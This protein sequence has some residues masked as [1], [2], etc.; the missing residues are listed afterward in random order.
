MGILQWR[1]VNWTGN[2][3]IGIICTTIG[4]LVHNQTVRPLKPSPACARDERVPFISRLRLYSAMQ[5]LASLLRSAT[6]PQIQKDSG[7]NPIVKIRVIEFFCGCCKN[8]G[9]TIP[10]PV[11][12][13]K[14]IGVAANVLN[15]ILMLLVFT[16]IVRAQ[17][18]SSPPPSGVTTNHNSRAETGET[19]A[20]TDLVGGTTGDVSQVPVDLHPFQLILP[21]AHLL[22]DWLVFAPTLRITESLR[23]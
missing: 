8:C 5:F 1:L 7:T 16:G 9:M 17:E 10:G 15:L 4:T 12:G 19:N 22:G 23:L 13:T 6:A 3:V 18:K 14:R 21:R 20:P 2:H 11:H